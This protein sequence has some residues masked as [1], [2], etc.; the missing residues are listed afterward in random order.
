MAKGLNLK[1]NGI[2]YADPKATEWGMQI[3]ELS[4]GEL[5]GTLAKVYEIYEKSMKED[6][7]MISLSKV[8]E[9]GLLIEGNSTVNPYGGNIVHTLAG[10]G[11]AVASSLS[12][13][14]ESGLFQDLGGFGGPPEQSFEGDSDFDLPRISPQDDDG[15]E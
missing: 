1:A 13:L 10:V 8:L 11:I 12:Q 9:D 7:G 3:N 15:L 6:I 4:M 5:D 2:Y 14:R